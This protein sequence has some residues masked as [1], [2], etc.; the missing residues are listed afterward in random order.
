MGPMKGKH[1][2]GR[3]T[4]KGGMDHYP[5]GNSPFHLNRNAWFFLL[6]MAAAALI[7]VLYSR[8]LSAPF[9]FDD[10]PNIRDNAF[11]RIADLSP[12]T[13]LD[14]GLKSL[15]SNRPVANISFALNY[16]FHG[17]QVLGY[18]VVNI[19]IHLLTGLFLFQL[20]KETLRIAK[21]KSL[22]QLVSGADNVPALAFAA[23]LIWLVHPLHTQ[24]VSYIVQRMTG[25]AAMFYVLSMLCYVSA[26]LSRGNARTWI[27]ICASIIS[28]VLALGSKEISVTLPFFILL[29]EWYFFQDLDIAWLKRGVPYI[30]VVVVIGII[31]ALF[32]LRGLHQISFTQWYSGRDFNLGQRVLSEFRIVMM[33]LGLI[34]LPYP[35]RLNL[36]YDFPLSYSL[37]NPPTTLISLLAIMGFIGFAVYSARKDRIVSF[38]IWWFFGN[39]V[40]ESSVIPLELVYEHRTYLPSM[41]VIFLAVLLL[42][43]Y[44]KPRWVQVA[45]FCSITAVFS[46]WTWQRNLVWQDE[47]SLFQDC[48]EKAPG[49]VR[50]HNNYGL[51]LLERGRVDEA[52][53][54]CGQAVDLAPNMPGVHNSLGTALM[55]KGDLAGAIS[56]FEKAISLDPKTLQ[57]ALNLAKALEKK[58][59]PADALK[60]YAGVLGKEP[61]NVQALNGMG[62]A[63]ADQG[64]YD[65]AMRYFAASLKTNP[66]SAETFNNMGNVL[67]MQGKIDEAKRHYLA[68]IRKN[69]GYKEAYYNLG[70]ALIKQGRDK[71]GIQYLENAVAVFPSYE[72]ARSSLAAAYYRSFN[73]DKAIRQFQEVLRMN[74]ANADAQKNLKASL[75]LRARLDLAIGDMRRQVDT[76]PG[77]AE[78]HYRLGDL[79]QRRGELDGAAE[80]LQKA[81]SISRL[82]KALHS[83]AVICSLKEDYGK[84]LNYLEEMRKARPDD[85]E[86][87][88][89]LACIYSKQGKDD[90]ALRS[91]QDA[92]KK[93]FNKWDVIKTDPDLS[94]VRG[95]EGYNKLII[96]D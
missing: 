2:Q 96:M 35:G 77:N 26:R 11:I 20:L 76:N 21:S 81:L 52:V 92:V 44:L 16:Y 85:P 19:F 17:Y 45:V 7:F 29:Y 58:G 14:A 15:A 50:A 65:E 9:L 32:Y 37:I 79:F 38:T 90:D 62:G 69:N 93:G 6:G 1:Q 54:Q 24:S 28:G 91:L 22:S 41:F 73:L 95:T 33:Y 67:L 53:Q 39:L 83:M 75:D 31:L 59:K 30:L 27:L 49:K 43:R 13:L 60:Y 57:F 80:E 66:D 48:V 84:A 89:N 46:L 74:P 56:Q 61:G 72:Q 63:L 82:P 4:G 23:A 3:E 5:A 51:A 34:F 68:A 94:H 70:M 87:Y 18:H 36:D 40:I 10:I 64:R 42:H 8:I 55:K 71:E 88:Y 78:L 47:L 12:G 25:M 86:V